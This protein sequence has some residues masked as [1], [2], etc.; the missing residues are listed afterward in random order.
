MKIL[1]AMP[2]LGIIDVRMATFLYSLLKTTT[3]DIEIIHTSR[4]DI[5]LARNAMIKDFLKWKHDYLLFLDDDNIPEQVNFIDKLL[6]ADKPIITAL[7]PSR[8]PDE[9]WVHRLCIFQEWLNSREEREYKQYFNVPE[10]ET[11][12]EIANCGMGCVLIKRDV[13]ETVYKQYQRPCEMKM[14]YYYFIDKQWYRD[15]TL[16]YAKLKDWMLRFKRYI[17]EDLL[18]FERAKDF[19]IPIF[20]HKGVKCTHIWENQ[21]ISVWE[22][23]QGKNFKLSNY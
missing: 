6:E 17:S 11:I 12:F 21:I 15:E 20:A 18:F 22:H 2:T 23:I 9:Q 13:V 16:D 7:V 4:L 5:S 1:I 10:W 8:K 14:C 3:H 19:S